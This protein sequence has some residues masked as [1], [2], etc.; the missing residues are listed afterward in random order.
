M[1]GDDLYIPRIAI[2]PN[3][4]DTPSIVDAN[5]VLSSTVALQS[6]E[7]IAGWRAQVFEPSRR[8]NRQQLA[9]GSLLNMHV[10]AANGMANENCCCSLAGKALDHDPT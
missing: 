9:P 1:I 8:I 6:L 3:E 7:T 2:P 4:T 5:A 10:D